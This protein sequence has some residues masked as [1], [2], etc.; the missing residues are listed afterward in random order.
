M[1]NPLNLA[2]FGTHKLITAF[3]YGQTIG[4]YR[5]YRKGRENVTLRFTEK[6][7]RSQGLK[8]IMKIK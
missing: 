2:P 3:E 1:L 7:K 6:G 5:F 4:R 8:L